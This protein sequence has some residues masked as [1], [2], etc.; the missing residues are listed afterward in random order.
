MTPRLDLDIAL[1]RDATG[2]VSR[3]VIGMRPR[4]RPDARVHLAMIDGRKPRPHLVDAPRG[5]A[6]G[7]HVHV[8][9]ERRRV[10][11]DC[12]VV[13]PQFVAPATVCLEEIGEIPPASA[14]GDA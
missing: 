9:S 11:V 13:R 14:A 4:S 6:I 7:E 8:W 3:M 5:F 1:E 10:W 12:Q 2:K